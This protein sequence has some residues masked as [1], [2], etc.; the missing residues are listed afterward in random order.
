[1]TSTEKSN[2]FITVTTLSKILAGTLFVCLPFLAFWIG[3]NYGYSLGYANGK[4]NV[5]TQIEHNLLITDNSISKMEEI[6][7]QTVTNVP[8]TFVPNNPCTF[9]TLSD[10]GYGLDTI[11][12]ADKNMLCEYANSQIYNGAWDHSIILWGKE[13]IYLVAGVET[14]ELFKIVNNKVELI[15]QLAGDPACSVLD[16]LPIKHLVDQCMD[17]NGNNRAIK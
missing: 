5:S 15:T 8:V 6:E 17:S 7:L 10:S 16:G 3:H 2:P 4:V 13:G 1:M 9:R 12:T 14:G 11:T